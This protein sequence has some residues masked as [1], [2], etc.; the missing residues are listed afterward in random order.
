MDQAAAIIRSY[1]VNPRCKLGTLCLRSA[2][3]DDGE[4]CDLMAALS[5]NTSLTRLDISG[6]N[7]RMLAVIISAG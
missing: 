3:V 5:R 4:C 2:D 6:E 1:L 7:S